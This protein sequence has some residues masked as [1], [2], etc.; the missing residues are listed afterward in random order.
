MTPLLALA[1]L[2][3]AAVSP[4]PSTSTSAPVTPDLKRAQ[5]LVTEQAR[6]IAAALGVRAGGALCPGDVK[7]K[8]VVRFQCVAP[9]EGVNAPFLVTIDAR[10]MRVEATQAV[11]LVRRLVQP[12]GRPAK[13]GPATPKVL[14]RAVGSLIQ[15]GPHTFRVLTIDGRVALQP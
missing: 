2:L 15:C 7:P 4:A 9:F 3:L 11:I 6:R 12:D 14:V 8:P 5:V 10:G 1:T 13:C